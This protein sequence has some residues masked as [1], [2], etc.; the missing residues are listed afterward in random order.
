[1]LVRPTTQALLEQIYKRLF[2]EAVAWYTDWYTNDE[3]YDRIQNCPLML[4][5][6]VVPKVWAEL[7]T[8]IYNDKIPYSD[9][10]LLLEEKMFI[11]R[12]VEYKL[13]THRF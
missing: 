10:I 12:W 3:A 9:C 13:I 1:M 7:E 8:L 5:S 6:F 11:R 2:S 4:V